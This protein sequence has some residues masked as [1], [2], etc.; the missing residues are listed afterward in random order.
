MLYCSSPPY[1][2]QFQHR[3]SPLLG[4]QNSQMFDKIK[5]IPHMPTCHITLLQTLSIRIPL[6][7]PISPSLTSPAWS[8]LR[9]GCWAGRRAAPPPLVQPAAG[10]AAAAAPQLQQLQQGLQPLQQQ[11]ALPQLQHPPA[12][13]PSPAHRR[14]GICFSVSEYETPRTIKWSYWPTLYLQR[15]TA[16]LHIHKCFFFSNSHIY[17]CSRN[18]NDIVRN[19]HVWINT[20]HWNH[21]SPW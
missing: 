8:S 2:S 17:I 18:F 4:H 14:P 11:A 13:A 19:F 6:A 7:S 21:I 1:R 9:R 15:E 12:A 20:T 3:P 10:A 16:I 5:V